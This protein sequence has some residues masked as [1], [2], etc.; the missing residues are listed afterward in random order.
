MANTILGGS[1]HVQP[2]IPEQTE[3]E[4]IRREHAKWSDATFGNVGP[5]GPLK[6]LSKEALEAAADPSDPLE[7]ADMQFLLWDAQRRM[8]I[9]DDFIT[10]AMIEKLEI[11][12]KRQWPEPKDGEP[13][14]HIKKQ[15][16]Q[17]VSEH[18]PVG[19]FSYGSECGFD[20]HNTEKEAIES[21]EAAIDDYRGDAC[22]GW[23]EETDSV[24]WGVILQQATKVDERP[25]TDDDKCDPAIDTV[26]DYALLPARED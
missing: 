22:D 13:R 1:Y 19:Y 2:V 10:K 26:C 8:G 21:A 15:L 14:L 4:K 20:W 18:K 11:N 7:W 23:S 17:P 12:K 5:V 25:R 3:R 6:H 9:S 16:A 24:C